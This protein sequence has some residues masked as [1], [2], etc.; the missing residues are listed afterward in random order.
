MYFNHAFKKD[1]VA[2][3]TGGAISL[4]TT[5]KTNDLTAGEVGLFD[6]QT[7]AAIA[8][9][10]SGNQ[11]FIL[12]QGSYRAGDKIGPFHGGYKESI[13]SK[14]INPR[15]VT[16]FF[17]VTAKTPQTQIIDVSGLDITCGNTYLLRLDIK[18]SP[19]LR[20]LTRFGYQTLDAFSGCCADGCDAPCNGDPVDENVVLLQWA[21]QINEHPLISPFVRAYVLNNA[22]TTVTGNTVITTGGGANFK[23]TAT[24]TAGV[25]VGDYVTG[26]GIA[27][28]AKVTA[29]DSGTAVTLDKPNVSAQTGGTFQFSTPIDSETYVPVTGAGAADVVG[30][31]RIE[32]SYVDTK[33]GDCTFQVRDHYELEPVQIFVS[34]VDESGDP[35]A[36]RNEI[37]SSTGVGVTEIQ[38]AR[39]AQGTG[40]K[41]LRDLILFKRYLQEPF[42]DGVTVDSMRM[43]ETEGDTS[44][45]EVDRNGLYDQVYILHN[46]PRFNNPSGT[47]DNDQYLVAVSVP[48]GTT[49]TAFTNLISAVLTAGGNT[50]PLETY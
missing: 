34:A 4:R 29:V 42:P 15:Y 28:G 43:R 16:R 22:A 49:T 6:A 33:F 45:S 31:L 2:A 18:G 26:P 3:V 46:V 10:G 19:V 40:E 24:T 17:K 32:A 25:A 27:P 48:T 1:F 7:Y 21:Q 14:V 8:A 44:L 47:F 41:L 9:A 35:C 37:N 11:P 5:G 12:A 13:K 50:V 30:H 36:V 20:T 23:I 39:T 38:E